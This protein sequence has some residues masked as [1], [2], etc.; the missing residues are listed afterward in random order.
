MYE[1]PQEYHFWHLGEPRG[2]L[3]DNRWLESENTSDE[4]VRLLS[5]NRLV[6]A[7]AGVVMG[8]GC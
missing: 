4:L 2:K 8:M 6:P 3:R 7:E 5:L 1:K